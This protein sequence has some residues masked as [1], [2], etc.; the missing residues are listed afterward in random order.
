MQSL[1]VKIESIATHIGSERVFSWPWIEMGISFYRLGKFKTASLM[2]VKGLNGC[3]HPRTRVKG[4]YFFCLAVF[5][6]VMRD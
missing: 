4:I 2:L 5:K 6:R 1:T 3:L